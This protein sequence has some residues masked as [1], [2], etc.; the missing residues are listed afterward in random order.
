[1]NKF[2]QRM[3]QRVARNQIDELPMPRVTVTMPVEL[4]AYL[5]AMVGVGGTS[6]RS[7]ALAATLEEAF[8]RMHAELAEEDEAFAALIAAEADKRIV[9]LYE[10]EGAKCTVEGWGFWRTQHEVVKPSQVIRA[11][12]GR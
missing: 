6:G 10:A 7:S 9:A 1:M 2:L 3:R 12:K 8:P 5:D 11:P 4:L